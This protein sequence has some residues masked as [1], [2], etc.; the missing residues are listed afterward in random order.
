[1]LDQGSVYQ[2]HIF[3]LQ[4][5]HTSTVKSSVLC[6][7]IEAHCQKGPLPCQSIL[8]MDQQE[9]TGGK[10]IARNC[11]GLMRTHPCSHVRKIALWQCAPAGFKLLIDRQARLC[12]ASENQHRCT[13]VAL[14]HCRDTHQG[15]HLW[16]GE[17]VRVARW[18]CRR[19]DGWVG[20][21]RKR[22]EGEGH[23]AR[24]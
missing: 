12:R 5:C 1:M 3:G 9:V 15:V 19:L 14:T 6:R 16:V 20:V 21:A 7:E 8:A 18:V 11:I 17:W 23:I 22:G 10:H 4:W 2:V 24:L 13:K